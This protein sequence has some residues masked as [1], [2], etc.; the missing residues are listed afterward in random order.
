MTEFTEDLLPF[1]GGHVTTLSGL[2]SHNM[3]D[4]A[5]KALQ[6]SLAFLTAWSISTGIYR[7]YFSP[8]ANIPGPKLAALTYW[9]E[10]YYEVWLGGKF[11]LKLEELHQ[12]YGPIVRINPI[13]VH[14]NDPEAIDLVLAG[15]GKKT[16]RHPSLAKKTG[17]PASMVTTVDHE[18]HRQRR[19]AVSGFFS[20]ASIRQLEP[21]LTA[22]MAKL[23]SRLADAADSPSPVA[24]HHV[25]KAC[26]SDVINQYAFGD[27]L[28]FMDR[29]DFGKPYF[30]ATDL[31]FGLNHVMIFFP[32]FA[33]LVQNTPNWFV[34]A[35]MPNLA[36]LVDK[37]SWWIDQV[38]EIRTSPN[39]ER[40]KS[41]IFEGI[42]SSSLPDADKTDQRLAAE[43]QLVIFA[44]EGTT[45][46]TLQAAVY[47]LLANPSV[48]AKLRAEL[49][50]AIPDPNIAPTFSQVDG[51]PYFNAIV[52]EVVRLHPGVM[53]RQMRV[54]ASHPV[55][56][57]DKIRT[58]REYVVPTGFL[59][60]MSPLCLH[61]DPTVFENP[62]EFRPQRWIDNPKLARAFL[63]F[64]R[65]TRGCLG[66]NLARREMAVVL[67]TLFRK[68]D[69]YRG[70]EGPTLELFDTLRARD[71]DANHDMIIPV[72]AKGSKGL[73]VKVRN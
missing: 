20:T 5:L 68:Y 45:A 55:V 61:M 6:L 42:L 10:C 31:F 16:D 73:R 67:A 14:Y 71:I 69:V 35:L 13:E 66:M 57:K 51:L 27:C 15:P 48:L 43:A 37:K 11:F 17:T 33:M 34:K 53:N 72:P 70:Q 50:E 12:Q 21:I 7:L 60:S 65:G 52:Q 36:E 29:A 44:G 38:R 4:V 39:P 26:T 49:A 62:Y 41:T 3:T 56:Y 63:G 1:L 8:I 28:G 58:G 9:Y 64:S 46:F 18:T 59:V 2:G 32:W 24:L 19:A 22:T 30:D 25:F 47:E 54:P 23:M 40:V